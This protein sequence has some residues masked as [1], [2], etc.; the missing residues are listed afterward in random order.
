MTRFEKYLSYDDV[1]IIG[2]STLYDYVYDNFKV[3]A[4]YETITNVSISINK[5]VQ[6]GNRII[7]FTKE[8][9]KSKYE[10]IYSKKY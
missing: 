9:D 7:Y 2:G 4:I 10:Q 3:N 1:F 8:I 5:Y 6:D